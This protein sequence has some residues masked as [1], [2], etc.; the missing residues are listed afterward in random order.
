MRTRTKLI[1]LVAMIVIGAAGA[2]LSRGY[3]RHAHAQPVK[4]FTYPRD[5]SVKVPGWEL[6]SPGPE[7]MP[8]LTDTPL[9]MKYVVGSRTVHHSDFFCYLPSSGNYSWRLG[10][11][12]WGT[13]QALSIV[14]FPDEQAAFSARESGIA[15]RIINRTRQTMAMAVQ[16]SKLTVVAQAQNEQGLWQD[17]ELAQ[18]SG[19]VCGFGAGLAYL[20]PNSYWQHAVRQYAG[21]MKTKLRYRLMV[22]HDQPAIYSNEF[23]GSIHPGQLQMPSALQD[24]Q[25]GM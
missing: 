8:V 20:E 16:D 11:V 14:A 15:V 1:L 18:P 5:V 19:L 13:D 21:P 22:A 4:W 12:D 3:C 25:P 2:T 17:I 23:A 6:V 7:A 10:E 9:V 24:T